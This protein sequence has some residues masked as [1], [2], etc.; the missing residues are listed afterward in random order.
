[1][2]KNKFKILFVVVA[3][4]FVVFIIANTLSRF[5]STASGD[6][7]LAVAK[8][9]VV[10]KKDLNSE[11]I[12][13]S[14]EGDHDISTEI[15]MVPEDTPSVAKGKIAPRSKFTGTFYIDPCDTEVNLEY[16]FVLGNIIYDGTSEAPNIEIESVL[17]NDEEVILNNNSYSS[18]IEVTSENYTGDP[19]KVEI[20]GV[21]TPKLRDN[22]VGIE[23]GNIN[24]PLD[25]YVEQFNNH[26]EASVNNSR[27]LAI[28]VNKDS[29]LNN[30]IISGSDL[31]LPDEYQELDYIQSTGTQW[32]DTEYSVQK[33]Y[34]KVEGIIEFTSFTNSVANNF[35][36]PFGAYDNKCSLNIYLD[37]TSASSTTTGIEAGTTYGRSIDTGRMYINTPVE[38]S[39]EANNGKIGG[40]SNNINLN[41]KS[42]SSELNTAHS[43][44]LFS[45]RS[46]GTAYAFCQMKCYNFSCYS[47]TKKEKDLIPCYRKSDG[48]PG[49]YDLVTDKFLVNKGSNEFIKGSNVFSGI[50]DYIF[51]GENAGK[52]LIPITI[53]NEIS[54]KYN[55]YIN[56]PLRKIGNVSDKLDFKNHQIIRNVGIIDSY[57]GES[58]TTDYISSTGGLDAGATIMYVLKLPVKEDIDDLPTIELIKGNNVISIDTKGVPSSFEIKY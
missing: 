45:S 21:W 16:T 55:I 36:L 5:I 47:K 39:I 24:L 37:K 32:I 42:Y 48:K 8:W 18:T 51:S 11:G 57:N 19:I 15:S 34:A 41:N 23:L 28:N 3:I 1:M 33:D 35:I 31:R 27:Q 17:V 50:G 38:F 9:H 14:S 44:A 58:I 22:A 4:V 49:M 12:D 56:E 2:S 40:Y 29:S 54:S 52:Y 6:G 30:Y 13:I 43:L 53:T 46:S 20:L 10:V 7:D 25:V 26:K